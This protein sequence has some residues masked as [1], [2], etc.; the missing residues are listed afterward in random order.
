M[1]VIQFHFTLMILRT[2]TWSRRG[3]ESVPGKGRRHSIYKRYAYFEENRL[4]LIIP[5]CEALAE[6]FHFFLYIRRTANPGTL[7]IIGPIASVHDRRLRL[8]N[9][10]VRYALRLFMSLVSG[11][12]RGGCVLGGQNQVPVARRLR[13]SSMPDFVKKRWFVCHGAVAGR[14]A[15]TL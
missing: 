8:S 4:R 1:V 7:S 10:R 5:C 14:S 15:T 9:G 13:P 11:C 3:L 2:V 12:I 6:T